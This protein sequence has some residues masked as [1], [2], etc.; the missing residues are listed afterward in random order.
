LTSGGVASNQ[1]DLQ[2]AQTFGGDHYFGQ[3]TEAGGQSI[4]DLSGSDCMVDHRAGSGDASARVTGE[5]ET[6]VRTA[7]H[8]LDG[9]ERELG[10]VDFKDFCHGR[11]IITGDSS[12]CTRRALSRC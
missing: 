6:Q 8:S 2:L 3:R 12:Y 7:G 10:T 4:H 1:V 5:N 11:Q 9:L